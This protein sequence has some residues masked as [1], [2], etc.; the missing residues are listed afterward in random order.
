MSL[1][2][3]LNTPS[4][5]HALTP[6]RFDR[7][8]RGSAGSNSIMTIVLEVHPALPRSVLFQ[9]RGQKKHER[10]FDVSAPDGARSAAFYRRVLCVHFWGGGTGENPVQ[11]QSDTATG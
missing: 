11:R 5:I 3:A 8:E 4:I 2:P 6:A 10:P 7:T 1:Y 9:R